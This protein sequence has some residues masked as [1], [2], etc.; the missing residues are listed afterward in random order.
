MA[1]AAAGSGLSSCAGGLSGDGGESTRC[2]G[3]GER[4]SRGPVWSPPT[5]LGGEGKAVSEVWLVGLSW[6]ETLKCERG[7]RIEPVLQVSFRWYRHLRYRH[8][9]Q[10][11]LRHQ[12]RALIPIFCFTHLKISMPRE[13]KNLPSQLNQLPG[14]FSW[15][16]EFLHSK[17]SPGQW[18]IPLQPAVWQGDGWCLSHHAALRTAPAAGTAPSSC[19]SSVDPSAPKPL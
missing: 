1:G 18:D 19:V 6:K 10:T 11:H 15:G 16:G 12:L 4:W 14:H 13:H 3:E 2:P 17:H 7:V 5:I 9:G 8:Q